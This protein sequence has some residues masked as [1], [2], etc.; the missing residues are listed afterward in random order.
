M[1]SINKAA[2]DAQETAGNAFNSAKDALTPESDAERAQRQA[3][4]S[5]EA[6]GDTARGVARDAQSG[7][8]NMA[9]QLHD[10]TGDVG[11]KM[12]GK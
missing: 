12:Q 10:A 8:K 7:A 3:K 5:V 1:D 4:E 6:G 2:K 9:D 11:R